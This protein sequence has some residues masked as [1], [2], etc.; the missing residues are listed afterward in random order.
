M[1]GLNQAYLWRYRANAVGQT[2]HALAWERRQWQ[3]ISA[4]PLSDGSGG[5]F[6]VLGAGTIDS[7]DA[8][9][10]LVNISA[11]ACLEIKE[12][13]LRLW[14]LRLG[15]A[16]DTLTE[17]ETQALKTFV[18]QRHHT[19]VWDVDRL[20]RQVQARDAGAVHLHS[21]L[22]KLTQTAEVGRV[23]KR[24]VYEAEVV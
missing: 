24:V 13:V 14:A 16:R 11:E 17:D 15:Q 7:A 22:M 18:D 8:R 10:V 12:H 23:E 20:A 1:G 4:K 6:K 2:L 5:A 9:F 19:H 3:R 21:A